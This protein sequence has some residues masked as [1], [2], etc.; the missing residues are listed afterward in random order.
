M[1]AG[2]NRL[3][4]LLKRPSL[5]LMKDVDGLFCSGMEA[6]RTEMTKLLYAFLHSPFE[7][8]QNPTT[9]HI[10]IQNALTILLHLHSVM[11]HC[12][13][14]LKTFTGLTGDG[15]LEVVA[16]LKRLLSNN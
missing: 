15:L 2:K 12:L 7:L 14:A 6:D 13:E 11:P 8:E 16:E 9:S 5:G 4:S 3:L 10:K 1:T